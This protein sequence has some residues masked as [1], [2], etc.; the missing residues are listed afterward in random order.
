M[1]A[2][3]FPKPVKREKPKRWG[4]RRRVA[5]PRPSDALP[6][7]KP[8]REEKTA[9]RRRSREWG[10]MAF[11]HARGCEMRLDTDTQRL[12]GITHICRGRLEFSHLSDLKRYDVGD[13]GAALCWTIHRGIDG[14]EGG[15]AKWYVALSREGQ[16]TI[17]M[18][19]ANR[20]RAAWD[21]LTDA[22]REHW[23]AIAAARKAG[24]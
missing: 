14:K 16:R 19:L 12:L 21:A 5:G 11:C 13:I 20:A 23:E 4:V 22:E 10:F 24:R 1:T 18:R 6:F 17:R 2:V 8:R 15:K 9:H 3:A 7:P